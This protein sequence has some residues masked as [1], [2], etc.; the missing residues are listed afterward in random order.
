[1]VG[2]QEQ[3]RDREWAFDV[4][5][6]AFA[7]AGLVFVAAESLFGADAV[8]QVGQQCI[9]AVRGCLGV[10]GGLVEVPLQRGLSGVAGAGRGTQIVFDVS[11]LGDAVHAGG[12]LIDGVVVA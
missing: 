11:F 5:V 12:D 7:R 10:E 3:G 6:T 1:P 9:P 8:G 4:V 2:V